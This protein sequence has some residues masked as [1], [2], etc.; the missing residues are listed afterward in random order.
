MTYSAI[1]TSYLEPKV[2]YFPSFDTVCIV[3]IQYKIDGRD[4]YVYHVQGKLK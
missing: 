4:L 3:Q 2:Y 1:L